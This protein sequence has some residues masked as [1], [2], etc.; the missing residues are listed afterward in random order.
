MEGGSRYIPLPRNAQQE[1]QDNTDIVQTSVFQQNICRFWQLE[2]FRGEPPG[3][4][5]MGWDSCHSQQD[6]SPG[7]GNSRP[8]PAL[9]A[10]REGPT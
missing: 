2:H 8:D 6:P 9:P 4:A 1:E 7:K 10:R 5:G 3:E